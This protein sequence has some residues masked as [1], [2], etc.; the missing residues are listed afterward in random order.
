[1]GTGLG[2]EIPTSI[3][4]SS[5]R[6]VAVAPWCEIAGTVVDLG[7]LVYLVTDHTCYPAAPPR[8]SS[9]LPLFAL[10]ISLRRSL[11]PCRTS[12][13]SAPPWRLLLIILPRVLLCARLSS[14]HHL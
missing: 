6:S 11:L 10:M 8:K 9:H 2:K 5:S 14:F 13:W 1:M 12:S 4:I 3:S 7:G